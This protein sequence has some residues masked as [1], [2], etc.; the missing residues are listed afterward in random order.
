GETCAVSDFTN[1]AFTIPEMERLHYTYLNRD[2]NHDVLDELAPCMDEIRRRLG[3]RLELV[4]AEVPDDVDP[5]E[6]FPFS[7][8]LRNTGFAPIYRERPVYLRLMEGE[9]VVAEKLLSDVDLRRVLPSEEVVIDSTITA[10][11]GATC[12]NLSLAL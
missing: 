4:T 2:Y 3:Y 9:E 5:G 6:V 11:S 12:G 10:P 7:V 1:C 8:T